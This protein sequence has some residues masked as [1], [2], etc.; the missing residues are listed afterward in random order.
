MFSGKILKFTLTLNEHS[1]KIVLLIRAVLI[2]SH[3]KFLF[4][5]AFNYCFLNKLKYICASTISSNTALFLE[6]I[7]Y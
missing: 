7:A 6:L 3:F 1:I 2:N 5:S 4:Y